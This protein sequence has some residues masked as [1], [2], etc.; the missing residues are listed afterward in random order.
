MLHEVNIENGQTIKIHETL[1]TIDTSKKAPPSTQIQK[2]EPQAIKAEIPKPQ[3]SKP[4]ESK[5]ES[6]KIETK[7]ASKQVNQPGVSI[8]DEFSEHSI[9][10]IRRLVNNNIK[11]IH[12]EKAILSTFNE[13]NL[14]FII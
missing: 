5:A 1:C 7:V 10:S 6:P 9:S 2:T 14:M 4:V 12:S 8:L 11:D 3:I 13:V